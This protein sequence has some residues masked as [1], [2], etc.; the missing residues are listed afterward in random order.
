LYRVAGHQ[1]GEARAHN[2]IGWHQTRFGDHQ[3]S[4]TSSQRALTMLHELGDRTGEAGT[5]HSLGH[6]HHHL[7]HHER[8]ITCYDH[9][10]DVYRE[11]GPRYM[12][13]DTLTNLGDTHHA[14]GNTDPARTAWQHALAI[15]DELSHPQAEQVQTKLHHLDRSRGASDIDRK[16]NDAQGQDIDVG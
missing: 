10:L 6:A 9:A 11:T 2:M 4:I 13:A 14:A 8:A 16:V 12:E 3:L 7:G 5:W 15:L 1:I